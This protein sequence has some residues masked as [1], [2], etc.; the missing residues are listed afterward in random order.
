MEEVNA[1]RMANDELRLHVLVLFKWYYQWKVVTILSV[2]RSS[3]MVKEF[4]KIDNEYSQHNVWRNFGLTSR[5]HFNILYLLD[6]PL[7]TL[8]LTRCS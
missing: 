3:K 4:K 2:D 6:L 1:L 5:A 7:E 8:F